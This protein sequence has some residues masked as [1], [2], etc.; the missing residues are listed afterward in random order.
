MGLNI[1][2]QRRDYTDLPCWDWMRFAGDKDFVAMMA[3]LPKIEENW[4]APHDFEYYTRPA[5]FAAWRQAVA[6]RQWDNPGRFEHLLDLLE[7]NHDA[8]IYV[9]W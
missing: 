3:S 9:S 1:C 5:D 8:W 2:V 7:Q 4:A 6:A